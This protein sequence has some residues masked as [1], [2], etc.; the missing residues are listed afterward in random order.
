MADNTRLIEK[1]ENR[2]VVLSVQL[3][4]LATGVVR[5]VLNSKARGRKTRVV[6]TE[7]VTTGP[8]AWFKNPLTTATIVARNALSLR[9]L[10]RLV[11]SSRG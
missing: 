3:R 11:A 1:Q 10:R 9:R 2:L 8:L 4:P 6:M 7:D 5:L